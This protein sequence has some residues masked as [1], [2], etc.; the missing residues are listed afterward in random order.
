LPAGTRFCLDEDDLANLTPFYFEAFDP[1]AVRKWV[2][3]LAPHASQE[4]ALAALIARVHAEVFYADKTGKQRLRRAAAD[5]WTC[6]LA[7]MLNQGSGLG[8]FSLRL[9]DPPRIDDVQIERLDVD[10]VCD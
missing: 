9:F 8:M 3:D 2:P 4:A 6:R 7:R 1:V 5:Q 10:D